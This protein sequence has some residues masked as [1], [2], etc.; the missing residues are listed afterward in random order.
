MSYLHFGYD[1]LSAIE[2]IIQRQT[3]KGVILNY[4]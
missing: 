2:I 1:T 3:L 4:F